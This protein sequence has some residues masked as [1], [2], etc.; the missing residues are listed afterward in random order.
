MKGGK[1]RRRERKMRRNIKTYHT[2]IFSSPYT[3][4]IR[5]EKKVL[6]HVQMFCSAKCNKY[7]SEPSF[8]TLKGTGGQKFDLDDLL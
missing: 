5:G 3:F 8:I 2:E 6:W 7:S 1:R 4:T